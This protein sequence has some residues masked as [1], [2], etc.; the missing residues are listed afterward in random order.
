MVGFKGI[1]VLALEHKNI[2][3]VG[4]TLLLAHNNYIIIV[5]CRT[6]VGGES[7][8]WMTVQANSTKAINKGSQ[9][10]LVPLAVTILGVK[11]ICWNMYKFVG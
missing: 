8:H 7:E 9:L 3:R 11:C 5:R 4:Q 6:S 10:W 1:R 2:R